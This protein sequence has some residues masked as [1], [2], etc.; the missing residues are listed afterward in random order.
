MNMRIT[1]NEDVLKKA[2][3]CRSNFSCL[4]GGNDCLC[5]VEDHAGENIHFITPRA[6]AHKYNYKMGFGFSY[7]CKCPVRKEVYNLYRI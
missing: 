2:E 3:K 4:A 5:E 1:I 6:D 7:I